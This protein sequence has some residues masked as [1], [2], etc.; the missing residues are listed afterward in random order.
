MSGNDE[1]KQK[2]NNKAEGD[3]KDK[4]RADSKANPNAKDDEEEDEGYSCSKCW[5]GYCGCIVSCCKVSIDE[6]NS[7]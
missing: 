2:L 4:S 5:N 3:D 1:E 7:N 6:D